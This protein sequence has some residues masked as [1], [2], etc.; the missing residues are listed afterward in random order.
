MW[1][2]AVSTPTKGFVR[3]PVGILRTEMIHWEVLWKL[4]N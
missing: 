1:Y 2:K 3:E 4:R